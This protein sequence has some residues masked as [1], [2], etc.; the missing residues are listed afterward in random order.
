MNVRKRRK[1]HD[2]LGHTVS[3]EIVPYYLEPYRLRVSGDGSGWARTSDLIRVKDAL[4]R[5]SY[6]PKGKHNDTTNLSFVKDFF[7]K[8]AET[9]FAVPTRYE[10][11]Y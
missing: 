6:V 2:L 11:G 10:C 8:P 4:S 1:R 7:A 9:H 5:L 3:V